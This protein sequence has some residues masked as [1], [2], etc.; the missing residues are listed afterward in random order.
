M[1]IKVK[2]K[3]FS[4]VA[5]LPPYERKKPMRQRLFWRTLLRIVSAPDLRATHFRCEKVGM[6]R[7][8]KKSPRSF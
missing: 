8:E 5:A 3:S 1:K 7:L 2:E 6:E 4:E